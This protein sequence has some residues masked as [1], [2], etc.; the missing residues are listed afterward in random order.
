MPPSIS[1]FVLPVDL[2]DNGALSPSG[3]RWPG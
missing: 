3:G 1:S 2:V